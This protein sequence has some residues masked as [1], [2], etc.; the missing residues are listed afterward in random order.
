MT[1][2]RFEVYGSPND[3]PQKVMKKLGITYQY[4]VP[5]SIADQWWF[6]NCENL[7]EKLPEYLYELRNFK[8]GE[9]LNPHELIGHGLDKEMADNIVSYKNPFIAG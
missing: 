6:F 9:W 3:H 5:Q 4:A 7:P 1:H 8:T 2:L